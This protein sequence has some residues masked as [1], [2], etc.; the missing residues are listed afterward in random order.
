MNIYITIIINKS[1]ITCMFPFTGILFV[2]NIVYYYIRLSTNYKLFNDC[3]GPFFNTSYIM[4]N[5]DSNS[6]QHVILEL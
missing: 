5:L 3:S 1:N 2:P 6:L 4:K